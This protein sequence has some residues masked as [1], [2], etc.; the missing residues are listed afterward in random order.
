MHFLIGFRQQAMAQ[1]LA[2][3]NTPLLLL[4]IWNIMNPNLFSYLWLQMSVSFHA[5]GTLWNSYLSFRFVAGEAEEGYPPCQ[6]W[7]YMVIVGSYVLM[8]VS[9]TP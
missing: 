3:K 8:N 1:S 6:M 5:V 4:S 2:Y 7:C 9:S